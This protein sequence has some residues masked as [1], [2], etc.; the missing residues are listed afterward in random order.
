MIELQNITVEF[1]PSTKILKNITA[2]F[3]SGQI[4]AIVGPNGSGK[5]TLIKTICGILRP[6]NEGRILINKADLASLP[7]Q[8]RAEILTYVESQHA[9]SFSYSVRDVISWGRWVY[10]RGKP[11]ERDFKAVASAAKTMGIESLIDRPVTQLSTGERKKIMLAQSLA[12]EAAYLLWDEPLAPL[13]LNSAARVVVTMKQ[14]A[15]V[16]STFITSFHDVAL[17]LRCADTISIVQDGHLAWTGKTADIA[18]REAV[19]ATF[20]VTTQSG[21]IYFL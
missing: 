17:A 5:T 11:T 12:T 4:H 6:L 20:G 14:L 16:G 8:N 7:L 9:S 10:H 1:T 13:D 18:A 15:S 19:E 21:G 2:R 3:P